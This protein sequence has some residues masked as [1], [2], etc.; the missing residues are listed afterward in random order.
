MACSCTPEPPKDSHGHFRMALWIALFL[1]LTL[2]FVELW[3]GAYANSASLWADA[4][5]FLGD[6]VNYAVS[7]AVLGMS[8]YWRATV[9]LFK[10]LT[11][12]IFGLVI[13]VKAAYVYRL[14][15]VPEAMTMGIIGFL[16][17]VTNVS[18]ALILYR[19]REGDSNMQSV[20]LCSR[21]D[22]IGNIAVM[23]AA[24][25]VFGTGSALPDLLVACL[26]AI[27]GLS[28]GYRIMKQAQKERLTGKGQTLCD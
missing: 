9:A 1:N 21:N 4:L 17:L 24:L 3:G 14:G 26:M 20:W 13:L 7:L 28:A 27:L 15:I 19:F 12:A 6:S 11:M 18:V 10:G 8:L 2:F 5:D 22:A 25:G 16:A 23:L